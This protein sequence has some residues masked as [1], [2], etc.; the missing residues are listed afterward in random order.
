M[1][2]IMF[3]ELDLAAAVVYASAQGVS[4]VAELQRCTVAGSYM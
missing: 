1:V 3:V 2:L 4:H